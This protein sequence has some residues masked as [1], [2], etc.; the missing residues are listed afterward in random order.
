MAR[1]VF[2][3]LATFGTSARAVQTWRCDSDPKSCPQVI[4][5][6]PCS[7]CWVS[8]NKPGACVN[9]TVHASRDH[10]NNIECTGTNA[11]AGMKVYLADAPKLGKKSCLNP[12]QTY[13]GNV[14]MCR[15][16]DSCSDMDVTQGGRC[17]GG[18]T[19]FNN[20]GPGGVDP[21]AIPDL[22][23]KRC[24]SA[25]PYTNGCPIPASRTCPK[26]KTASHPPTC[27]CTW[28]S[29]GACYKSDGSCCWD[30]CCKSLESG[31]KTMNSTVVA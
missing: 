23:C 4:T 26:C 5:C 3:L 16:S 7:D 15:G 27:D 11:C 17:A 20:G 28:V 18:Q 14:I 22:K 2:L 30:C 19:R 21:S 12:G 24:S 6:N 8:C 10:V 31:A 29:H 9:K 13:A 1:I 25:D